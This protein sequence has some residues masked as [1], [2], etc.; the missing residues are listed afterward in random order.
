MKRLRDQLCVMCLSVLKAPRG[1]LDRFSESVSTSRVL[2]CF[3]HLYPCSSDHHIK[4]G[5]RSQTRCKAD[6]QASKTGHQ[7][8]LFLP[9][10]GAVNYQMASHQTCLTGPVFV[11]FEEI[12]F[13]PAVK[14]APGCLLSYYARPQSAAVSPP[15]QVVGG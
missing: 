11:F 6:G 13:L 1:S 14:I 5:E 3:H 2:N 7:S 15:S 12:D 9:T 10:A 4:L 8:S